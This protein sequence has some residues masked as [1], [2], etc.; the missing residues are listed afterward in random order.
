MPTPLWWH[1][2]CG[3]VGLASQMA[4][5]YRC[6]Q[7]DGFETLRILPVTRLTPPLWPPCTV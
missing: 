1:C 3:W 2:T 6:P 7:C 5:G 4:P